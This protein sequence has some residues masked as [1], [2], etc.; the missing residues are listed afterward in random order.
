MAAI[1][2]IFKVLRQAN[3]DP[4]FGKNSKNYIR[5]SIFDTDQVSD[6]VTV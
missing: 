4:K 3:F 6:G 5:K 2:K 1:F